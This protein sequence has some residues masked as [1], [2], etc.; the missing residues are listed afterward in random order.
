MTLVPNGEGW[1]TVAMRPISVASAVYRLWD[2]TRLR[3]AM[4]WQEGWDHSGQHGFRYKHV[5]LHVYWAMALQVEDSMFSGTDLA[6]VL[7]D[8]AKCFDRLPHTIMLRQLR[9]VRQPA[10]PLQILLPHLR[11]VLRPP[12]T[13]PPRLHMGA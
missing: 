8:Y 12:L 7:L 1:D 5:T 9:H 6:G 4:R 2:D 13:S 10:T 11:P 3:D